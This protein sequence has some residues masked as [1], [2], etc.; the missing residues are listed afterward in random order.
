MRTFRPKLF[1][2]LRDYSGA[3]FANDLIAGIIVAIIALPLSIAL[4]IAS[5]VSPEQG[6]YTAVVAGFIIAFLGG[7]RV[8]ISGPTAAFAAIVAGIVATH[9]IAGLTLAAVIAGIILILMGVFRF[10]SL[11][12]YIPMTLTV[13]FTAGIAVT[14]IIGQIKDF[15]GLTFAPGTNAIETLNKLKAIFASISSINFHAVIVGCIGLAIL[16]LWP[17][18]FKNGKSK[19][20]KFLLKIPPSIIAVIVGILLVSFTPLKVNTIGTLYPTL[21]AGFP[22]PSI[23]AFDFETVKAVIPSAFTIAV[24][25]AI[26]SLLSCVVSDGMI[27]DKHNSNTEL[28]AL[29]IGNIGSAVFGG[30]PATGAIARTAAN[31]KNGGRTPVSGIIHALVLLLFLLVLMPLAK[32]IP[33]P[34]IA[35]I[36]FMVAYNM[37]EWRHFVHIIKTA[38]LADILVLVLTFV[39]T[40]AFDLVVAISVGLVLSAILFMKRMSDETG[41][42]RWDDDESKAEKYKTIPKN[43]LVYEFNGPMFFA[44]AEK[45]LDFSI[46]EDTKALILRMGGVQTVDASAMKNLDLM[47]AQ[48][49]QNGIRLMLSHINPFPMKV[50]KK[51]GF[52]DKLGTENI[53]ADIDSA[54]EA[55]EAISSENSDQ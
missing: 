19:V 52:I 7:S 18:A 11:I 16:I 3:K 43:T 29:G 45:L 31:V 55:A 44:G 1:D 23:P 35:A 26:E 8:N 42:R 41:I 49:S 47:L 48:C 22:T 28:I 13:G 40:V 20:S 50:L 21:K 15:F 4:A 6:L 5:G 24:L 33:M 36:L 34:I 27:G 37:S 32:L 53:F 25:A 9:G 12:K 54:L 30:I 17:L 2:A 46:E 38:P 39:L 14:I 51:A 10:G